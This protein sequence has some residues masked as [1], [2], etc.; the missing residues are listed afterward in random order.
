MLICGHDDCLQPLV[1][2]H[3]ER[4]FTTKHKKRFLTVGAYA[5]DKGKIDQKIQ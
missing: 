5:K 3:Y 4:H 1:N 2:R